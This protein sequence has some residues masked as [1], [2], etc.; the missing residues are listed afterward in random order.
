MAHHLAKAA[1]V[2]LPLLLVIP[3]ALMPV[4]LKKVEMAFKIQ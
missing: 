1:A 4:F 3:G 2:G